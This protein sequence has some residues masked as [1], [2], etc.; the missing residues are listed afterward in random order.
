MRRRVTSAD[1]RPG[2]YVTDSRGLYEVEY[3][4]DNGLVHVVNC[5]NGVRQVRTLAHVCLMW[6]VQEAPE[7]PDVV[8]LPDVLAA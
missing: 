7:L 2:A 8:A 3:L 5:A 6:I 4:D 1:L